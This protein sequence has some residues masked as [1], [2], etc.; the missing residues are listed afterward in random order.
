LKPLVVSLA[1][2][3]G[4]DYVR[5]WVL[6]LRATGYEGEVV[7]ATA[8]CDGELH[9]QCTKWDVA[10]VEIDPAVLATRHQ[11]DPITGRHAVLARVLEERYRDHFV[12]ACDVRDVFFQTDPFGFFGPGLAKAQRSKVYLTSEGH[13]IEVDEAN[14]E[15][16]Y[17]TAFKVRQLFSAREQELV[18]GQT[19]FNGG[20]L[21]GE[22]SMLAGV[23]RTIYLVLFNAPFKIGD[24]AALNV[25]ARTEP[26]RSH[27]VAVGL[28]DAW[29]VHFAAA[30]WGF[31][32]A[33]V[34]P[35]IEDGLVKTHDGRIFSIVHQYD[36][37]QAL[38]AL[39]DERSWDVV[40]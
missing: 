4:W 17:W 39:V 28:E 37:S 36:R 26:L 34:T 32:P 35:K 7:L 31:V 9:E 33:G 23:M 30:R 14:T 19:V 11:Q 18:R 12:I 10:T 6:S 8:G 13:P 15:G 3:A 27:V 24:Q 40:R 16:R 1:T 22:S 5:T 29:V 20:V 21:C 2:N 25:L 38:R